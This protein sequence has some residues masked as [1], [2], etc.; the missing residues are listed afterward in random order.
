VT[1]TDRTLYCDA[2]YATRGYGLCEKHR[3]LF[4]ILPS[5]EA[6][7]PAAGRPPT[8]VLTVY[9]SRDKDSN[10]ARAEEIW[11]NGPN[12]VQRAFAYTLLEAAVEIEVDLATGQS[13]ALAFNGVPLARPTDWGL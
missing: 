13:R 12:D 6:I 9:V 8:H 5:D 10:W 3:H 1:T 2:C 4:D 11:P 7:R